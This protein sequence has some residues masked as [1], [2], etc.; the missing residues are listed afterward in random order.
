MFVMVTSPSVSAARPDATPTS[1]EFVATPDELGVRQSRWT[2]AC[3]CIA[4]SALSSR[5]DALR[6]VRGV[7]AAAVGLGVGAGIEVDADAVGAAVEAEADGL[8]EVDVMA[9]ADPT[10]DLDATAGAVAAVDALPASATLLP[11]AL[12][13]ASAA[14]ATTSAAAASGRL[15]ITL[16]IAAVCQLLHPH[17][18]LGGRWPTR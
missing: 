1:R 7:D 17:N 2:D 8:A 13:P 6:A 12:H 4:E 5:A 14:R 3:A 16:C 15:R 11:L 10:A 9:D 18:A